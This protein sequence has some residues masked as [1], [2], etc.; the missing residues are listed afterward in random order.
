MPSPE[1]EWSGGNDLRRGPRP[2]GRLEHSMG[3][4]CRREQGE[5]KA[6]GT[7]DLGLVENINFIILTVGRRLM[8]LTKQDISSALHTRKCRRYRNRRQLRQEDQRRGCHSHFGEKRSGHRGD[9]EGADVTA[10]LSEPPS[11][12]TVRPWRA[13]FN[14]TR[15]AGGVGGRKRERQ[16]VCIS[17]APHPARVRPGVVR[18][19]RWKP[20]VQAEELP[21]GEK[22]DR[23]GGRETRREKAGRSGRGPVILSVAQRTP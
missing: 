10:G 9:K 7:K 14:E 3:G 21:K 22:D 5:G 6:R 20:W 13:P 16:G 19:R 1:G 4:R 2:R 15:A 12:S 17:G 11:W 23:E 18:K 8:I